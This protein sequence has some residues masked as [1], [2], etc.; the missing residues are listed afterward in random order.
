M[1]DK[2]TLFEQLKHSFKAQKMFILKK[3]TSYLFS[4]GVRGETIIKIDLPDED[5]GDRS[6]LIRQR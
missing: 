5:S 2:T 1:I 6:K 4:V 3:M